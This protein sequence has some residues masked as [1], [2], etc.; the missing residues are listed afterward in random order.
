MPSRVRS[1]EYH[2]RKPFHLGD[3]ANQ[4]VHRLETAIRQFSDNLSAV[5]ESL[6]AEQRAARDQLAARGAPIPEILP[7]AFIDR[8]IYAQ[9]PLP[10]ELLEVEPRKK[11]ED[12]SV[13]GEPAAHGAP[14][15]ARG[16]A[17][18]TAIEG[19]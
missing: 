13:S 19:G 10:R 12:P 15:G 7:D 5:S 14:G 6:Q 1:R 3:V 11:L 8:D 2:K 16:P 18:S 9:F 4:I 17:R